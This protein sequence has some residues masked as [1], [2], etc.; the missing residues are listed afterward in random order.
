MNIIHLILSAAGSLLFLGLIFRPLEMAFPRGSRSH[1]SARNGG[2]ISASSSA[3]ICCGA[4]SCSG[5]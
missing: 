4:E 5:S 2:Q 3:N 1:S